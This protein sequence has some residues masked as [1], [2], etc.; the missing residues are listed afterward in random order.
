MAIV[1]GTSG[2]DILDAA[3]GVTNGDDSI[4]GFGG[5]DTIFGLGGNDYLYG[6][7][8]ADSLDGGSGIDTALYL[9]SPEAVIVSLATAAG[10]GGYGGGLVRR[11]RERHRLAARRYSRRQRQRQRTPGRGGVRHPQGWRRGRLPVGPVQQR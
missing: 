1:N 9:A 4:Y 8:G 5:D 7:A 3:D 2:S 6:G 10:Q 11:Y